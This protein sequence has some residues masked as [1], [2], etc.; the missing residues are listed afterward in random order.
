MLLLLGMV[1]GF[2]VFHIAGLR[3]VPLATQAFYGGLLVWGVLLLLLHWKRFLPWA[4]MD[5]LF[6]AFLIFV[7]VSLLSMNSDVL[8]YAKLLP[9]LVLLP[10]ALGRLTDESDVEIF[11]RVLPW[12]GVL[13]LLLCVIDYLWV[14]ASGPLYSRISFF[15]IDHSPLLIARVLSLST[16]ALAMFLA[17]QT[18]SSASVIWK[19]AAMWAIFGVLTIAM[20]LI[21]ARGVLIVTAVT[22]VLIS[23][24]TRVSVLRKLLLLSYFGVMVWGSYTM[25]PSPV[26][27]FYERLLATGAGGSLVGGVGNINVD[28]VRRTDPRCKPL[29]EGVNSTAIRL[30][31]YREAVDLSLRH[32]LTGVGAGNFGNHSCAGPKSYPHSTILQAFA[33]LG[34]IGGGLLLALFASTLVSITRALFSKKIVVP[35]A[36]FWL[37]LLAFFGMTDQVYGSYFMAAGSFFIFG[38]SGRLAVRHHMSLV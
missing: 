5:V 4:L 7:S 33:E 10:Y 13:L 37:S 18:L 23:A 28:A 12:L 22:L 32:P 38:V 20:V 27:Q 14:P 19:T 11:L 2:A 36:I 25:L 21:A 15:G 24:V 34:I 3:W 9:F 17:G 6:L 1:F 8:F 30:V 31:L 16:L 35:H 29:L 26:A